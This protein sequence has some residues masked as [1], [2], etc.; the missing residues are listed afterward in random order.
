VNYY[1]F[2]DIDPQASNGE[3]E[4][5]Y[6]KKVEAISRDAA[7]RRTWLEAVRLAWQ[8]RRTNEAKVTLADPKS[9]CQYDK[10]LAQIEMI[11]NYPPGLL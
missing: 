7:G 1:K 2:L 10:I 9:R 3:I 11:A 6:K 4:A 8:V 5:A